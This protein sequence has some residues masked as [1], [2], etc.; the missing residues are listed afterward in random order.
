MGTS[1]MVSC[2][3]GAKPIVAKT[4]TKKW[5]V[6]CPGCQRYYTPDYDSRD[7]AISAWND[8]I[9]SKKKNRKG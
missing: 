9:E 4:N 1:S 2:R 5:R 3:C 6:M 7:E 8:N